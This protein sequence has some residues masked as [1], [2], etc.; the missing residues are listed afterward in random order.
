MLFG[1]NMM[2][3]NI[4]I[5]T[6]PIRQRSIVMC[7]RVCLSVSEHIFGLHIQSS[8]NFRA[9]GSVFWWRCDT[10]STS[11]FM[12]DDMFAH[13]GQYGGVSMPLQRVTSMRRRGGYP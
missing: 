4:E 13:I 3:T 11:G 10:L 2:C 12:H 8:S 9:R 7:V 5:F 1:K 6:P